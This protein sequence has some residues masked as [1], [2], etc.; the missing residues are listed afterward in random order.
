[1]GK[2]GWKAVFKEKNGHCFS[3]F[4]GNPDQRV[5]YIEGETA[6]RKEGFGPLTCFDTEEQAQELTWR[7]FEC[8]RDEKTEVLPCEFEES[9]DTSI[10]TP[11]PQGRSAIPRCNLSKG[12]QLA[13][14]ITILTR[15]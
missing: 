14:S 3:I 6:Y 11:G 8:D 1:M 2:R 12:T 4:M 7:L 13:D 9:E 10:W 5:E 15:R